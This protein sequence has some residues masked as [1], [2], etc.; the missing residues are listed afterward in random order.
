MFATDTKTKFIMRSYWMLALFGAFS[1]LYVAL[2]HAQPSLA[3]EAP[4]EAVVAA[5]DA[6]VA[7]GIDLAL[8]LFAMLATM[9]TGLLTWLGAHV[10][11]WLK[12]R[13]KNET[14]GGAMARFSDSVF[15]AVKTVNQTLKAEIEKAKDPKSPGGTAITE[16]E[17]RKLK[18]AAWNA[19]KAEYGGMVGITKFLGVL[20]LGTESA[21]TAWVDNKIEAAVHDTKAGAAVP[22]P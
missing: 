19:L 8:T 2:A 20:G 17:A 6:P 14:V 10:S 7:G 3:F 11:K 9:L 1:L 21:V 16:G 12:A 5:P 18:D 22:L 4:P 15:A 13:T